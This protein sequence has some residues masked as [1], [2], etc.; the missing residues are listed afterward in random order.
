MIIS[1]Y[2]ITIPFTIITPN[3][4]DKLNEVKVAL[5]YFKNILEVL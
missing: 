4:F 2:I 5:S 1:T 3:E